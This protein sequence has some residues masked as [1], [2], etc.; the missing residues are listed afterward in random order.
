MRRGH[1]GQAA[2]RRAGT[3]TVISM[4]VQVGPLPRDTWSSQRS[5][6]V[7]G[8]TRKWKSLALPYQL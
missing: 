3:Y 6:T 7:S 2:G 4:L 5:S 8:G 1:L